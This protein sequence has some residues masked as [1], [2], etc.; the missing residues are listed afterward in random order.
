VF[1]RKTFRVFEQLDDVV[2]DI[3]N[4]AEANDAPGL[5]GKHPFNQLLQAFEFHYPIRFPR[6]TTV[7]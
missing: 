2:N 1:L 5:E 7:G 6:F 3:V 4:F